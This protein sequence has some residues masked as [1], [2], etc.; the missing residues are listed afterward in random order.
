MSDYK[1]IIEEREKFIEIR[2]IDAWESFKLAGIDLGIKVRKSMSKI[3]SVNCDDSQ[4][5]MA[6]DNL[7]CP[8]CVWDRKE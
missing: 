2:K 3:L 4:I 8:N 1:Q 7:S 5:S 6:V